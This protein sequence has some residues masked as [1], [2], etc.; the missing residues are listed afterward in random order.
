MKFRKEPDASK[1]PC[2]LSDLEDTRCRFPISDV[3]DTNKVRF[4]G[5]ETMPGRSYCPN[6]HK[7]AYIKRGAID[8]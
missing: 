2:S 7:I 4:C 6:H 3:N 5:G 8:V 1:R